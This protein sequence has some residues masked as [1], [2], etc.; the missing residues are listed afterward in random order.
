M[1]ARAA[2]GRILED[3]WT[4]VGG[5]FVGTEL[6]R[7]LAHVQNKARRWGPRVGSV[8]RGFGHGKCGTLMRRGGGGG[9]R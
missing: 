7:A 6:G 5:G 2:A 3:R 9:E 4:A 8:A 1:E